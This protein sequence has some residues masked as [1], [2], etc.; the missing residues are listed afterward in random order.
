M[1]TPV[2]IQRAIVQLHSKNGFSSRTIAQQLQISHK[3][4]ATIK[5]KIRECD[6][7]YEQ[8]I[9]LDDQAFSR[10]LGTQL[11]T[12][13]TKCILPDYA[14]I[15]TELQLRD[16][17]LSLLWIEYRVGINDQNA[18]QYLSYSQ[19]C[20]HYNRWLKSQ[21]ISMRQFHKP[22]EKMFVDFCGRTMSVTDFNTGDTYKVQ[23]FVGVL[24]ASGY[25][26]AIAVPSQKIADWIQ[27]HVKAFEYFEGVPQQVVPDNLK[28][29]VIKHTP[30][31]LIINKAYMDM[32]EHY[33]LI[34]NPARSRKPKDKSLAEVNVQIVQRWVLA[35]L[36]AHKFFSVHELNIEIKQRIERLN[37]KTSKKYKQSRYERF[38][39]LDRNALQ[40]LPLE[41]YEAAE[42]RYNLRIPDDYHI[43]HEKHFYSVPYQ[44]RHQ[45][46]DVRITHSTFEILLGRKRIASH[47][48]RNNPGKSTHPE[49]MPLEHL[50]YS[51]ADPDEMLLWAQDIGPN[52]YEW[53]RQNLQDRRDYANGLK[54]VS[55]LR[56]WAREEQNHCR[57]ESAC[58]FALSIA[59]LTFQRLQS[60]IR[61]NSDLRQ[62]VEAT[63]WVTMHENVRGPDY[64][65]NTEVPSC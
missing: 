50:R 5:Q 62:S 51:E 23:V 16:M 61:S 10:K 59:E 43:M 9:A 7:S 35:P 63:N 27:C 64:Y 58:A 18:D 20:R 8:L 19:F 33:N 60:I 44:H 30:Q 52:V 1:R 40:S 38:L 22:G 47:L 45:I 29:A 42:W 14:Q 37:H 24:G 56:S 49:H 3:T 13:K 12:S 21:R 26:F 6:L 34:I 31:E 11:Q 28:S 36:R 48:L 57:L 53:A 2:A 39:E 41:R 32:A 17:T 46:V 55:R 25:T 54:S 65:T 15:Q 4:V